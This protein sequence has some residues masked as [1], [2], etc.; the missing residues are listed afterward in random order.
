MFVS[1]KNITKINLNEANHEIEK[2]D[3][4]YVLR[5]EK[6]LVEYLKNYNHTSI[7]EEISFKMISEGNLIICP[8]TIEKKS[9]NEKI[10]NFYGQPFEFFFKKKIDKKVENKLLIYLSEII[11]KNDIT[12]INMRVK[13]DLKDTIDFEKYKSYSNLISVN[14]ERFVNI[15]NENKKIMKGFSAGLRNELKK[16]YDDTEYIIINKDN[17]KKNEILKMMYL[18]E[19]ISKRKTRTKE[20]WII[21]EKMILEKKAFLIKCLLNGECISYNLFFHNS[22]VATW[23]SSCTIREHFKYVRNL[24]STV[25]WLAMKYVKDTHNCSYFNLG[26]ETIFSREPLSDKEK[27]IEFF[28]GKFRGTGDT[29]FFFDLLPTKL[30][31]M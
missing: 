19:K 5:F 22:I 25:V 11:L 15:I 30:F 18:H 17:Y 6:L 14:K 21:N 13:Q 27:N 31:C 16:S 29:Y 24:S 10:L 7:F 2:I 12:K 1:R 23:F 26:A 8:L 9:I 3:Q 28:K 4:I 20:S